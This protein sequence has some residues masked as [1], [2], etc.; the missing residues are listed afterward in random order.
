MYEWRL[1]LPALSEDVRKPVGTSIGFDVAIPDLDVDGSFSWL[2]WGQG[3]WKYR[4]AHKLEDL[5]LASPRLEL[6]GLRGRVLWEDETEGSK[7]GKVHLQS[8]TSEHLLL[9][10][11]TDARGVH[12]A[13]VPAGTY[14]LQAGYRRQLTIAADPVTVTAGGETDAGQVAVAKP[15][16]GRQVT[17]GPGRILA[18]EPTRVRAVGRTVPAGPER[19]GVPGTPSTRSMGSPPI[20]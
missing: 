1:D 7:L 3:V 18:L 16:F 17:A 11:A 14:R 9:T 20:P 19:A 13:Q 10:L 2:S 4:F 6:G 15:P 12:G 5:L 8:L